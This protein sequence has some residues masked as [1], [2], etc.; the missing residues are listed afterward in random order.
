MLTKSE[1]LNNQINKIWK[2]TKNP[3]KKSM[4]FK[5]KIIIKKKNKKS[6]KK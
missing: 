5:F 1:N 6:L 2:K 3:N 4:Q